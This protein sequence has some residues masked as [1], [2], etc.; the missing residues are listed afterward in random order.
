MTGSTWAGAPARGPVLGT[1]S[2]HRGTRV[3]RSRFIEFGLNL[4]HS[5]KILGASGR[6]AVGEIHQWSRIRVFVLKPAA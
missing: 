6:T 1:G 3:H 5:L 2:S 4:K